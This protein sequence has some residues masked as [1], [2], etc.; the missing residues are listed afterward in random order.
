MKFQRQRS[1]E[2]GVDLTPLIDVV[3]LLLIFLMVSTTLPD[4]THL[5]IQLPEADGEPVTT[6]VEQ[7]ELV[8]NAD[9]HYIVNGRTLINNRRGTLEQA[10]RDVAGE[11]NTLPFVIT[12]DARTAHEFVIRAMD[13]AGKLGF[14]RISFTTDP[15]SDE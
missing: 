10:I 13:V 4:D 12:A 6:E 2:V 8:V 1:R 3:F 15:T 14:T 7:V 9:G 11:S 5:N